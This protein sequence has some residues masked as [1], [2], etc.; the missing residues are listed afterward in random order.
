[1]SIG[2]NKERIEQNNLKLENI[3][4]EVSDLPDFVDTTDANAI[5]TNITEGKTA[6]VNNKR[7]VGTMNNNGRE[8]ITP[9][10]NE[11]SL[12]NGY[13]DEIVVAPFTYSDY[14]IYC[15]TMAQLTLGVETDFKVVGRNLYTYYWG[16]SLEDR[17]KNKLDGTLVG[18][19]TQNTNE[20]ITFSGG[21][22]ITGDI[23]SARGAFEIYCMVNPSYTP[24]YSTDWF[25]SGCLVG[26]ELAGTEQDFGIIIDRNGYFGIGY[27]TDSIQ[28]GG[29]ASRDGKFHHL[30]LNVTDTD[31]T[32]YIDG[33]KKAYVAYSMVGIVPTK[34]GIFWNNDLSRS[35][36]K[37]TCKLFRYYTDILTEKEINQNYECCKLGIKHFEEENE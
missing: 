21:Y 15:L 7:I 12:S 24:D 31:L 36:V 19:Y 27:S 30:V 9:S 37:G 34:Y 23:N 4:N 2:T 16:K 28:S 10:E 8:Y 6:Y 14:Y 22:G 29:V 33:I 25:R 32:L 3:K 26:C 13:Y 11:Q 17:T 5:A 20:T 1:M 35:I 18:S